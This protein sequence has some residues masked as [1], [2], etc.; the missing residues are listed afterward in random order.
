[1]KQLIGCRRPPLY[2]FCAPAV[3]ADMPV[4]GHTCACRRNQQLDRLL[5]SVAGGGYGMW[6]QAHTFEKSLPGVALSIETTTGR[7]WLGF[8]T[9]QVGC[10]YQV[11]ELG[12]R[13]V[14]RMGISATLP[15]R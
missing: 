7:S 5:R 10:D 11:R 15:G 3:A 1:M 13:R 2:V 14:R 9:G 4:E 12:G 6:N 8:G